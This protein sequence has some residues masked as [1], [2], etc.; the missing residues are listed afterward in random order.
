MPDIIFIT[1]LFKKAGF[2]HFTRSFSLAKEFKKM[3]CKIYFISPDIPISIKKILKKEKF[4]ISKLNQLNSI[5]KFNKIIIIDSYTIKRK[6][7]N[8]IDK[9]FFSVI[10]D[11][12]NKKKIHSNIIIR[13]NLGT[14]QKNNGELNQL[15]GNKYCIIRKEI[16]KNKV[17]N[18]IKKKPNFIYITF[19]GYNKKKEI[20]NFFNN[21]KKI[22]YFLN[23]PIKF[24]INIQMFR[25]EIKKIFK[26]YQNI[27]IKFVDLKVGSNFKFNKIEMSINAGGVTS[28]EMLYLKIPQIIMLLSED[29]KNNSNFIKD[30]QLGS[31]FYKTIVKKNIQADSDVD[32]FIKN[33][34]VFKKNLLKKKW[35]DGFGAGRIASKILK[36]YNNAK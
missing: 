28:A 32:N 33:Y 29:Q 5:K 14:V 17:S 36:I 19:G 4:F 11:D 8:F 24:Y 26:N 27:Q 6:I 35:L 21:L 16:L 31:V 25:K 18:F 22:K 30:N 7:K 34:P 23:N 10:F 20:E 3:N 2:G 15:V 1:D 12:Y 13:N 9:F